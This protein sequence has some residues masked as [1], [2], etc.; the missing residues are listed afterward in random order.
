[1]AATD[2]PHNSDPIR[3]EGFDFEVLKRASDCQARRCTITTPHG[4]VETPAFV[5]CATK[6]AI[7]GGVTPDMVRR[8]CFELMWL[9]HRSQ[10]L[11]MCVCVCVCFLAL[12]EIS[13]ARREY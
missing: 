4:R 9:D 11:M 13:V 3:Y 1:M 8:K 10:C 7:K 6:A 12:C 2:L 5:F